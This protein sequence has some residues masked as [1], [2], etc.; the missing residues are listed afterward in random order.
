VPRPS[1]CGF[2]STTMDSSAWIAEATC[3]VSSTF[4]VMQHRPGARRWRGR[5]PTPRR[6]GQR[7][8]EPCRGLEMSWRATRYQTRPSIRHGSRRERC[9]AVAPSQKSSPCRGAAGCGRTGCSQ[10][11]AA[12]RVEPV[13]AASP[14]RI[15]RSIAAYGPAPRM[16]AGSRVIQPA[17]PGRAAGSARDRALRVVLPQHWFEQHPEFVR[18]AQQHEG[19]G[20]IAPASAAAPAAP[21][22]HGPS[23]AG[24]H[25]ASSTVTGDSGGDD[26]LRSPAGGCAAQ[27]H[28]ARR[29]ASARRPGGEAH[30]QPEH[31]RCSPRQQAGRGR[32]GSIPFGDDRDRWTVREQHLGSARVVRCS[33]S[34][35]CTGRLAP[36]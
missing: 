7:R 18:Q 35:G 13:P 10:V 33:R 23:A 25:G 9:P 20:S 27:P 3:R 17:P 31:S 32:A 34:A 19:R 16:R 5:S 36:S 6:A 1:S 22:S 30:G 21:P 24:D 11:R 14:P 15:A 8:V 2:L 26:F 29:A 4:D 12:C 28:A